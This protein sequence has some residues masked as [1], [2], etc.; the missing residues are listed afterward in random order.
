M[1]KPHRISWDDKAP[2]VKQ[3]NPRLAFQLSR[4]DEM[5]DELY[6]TTDTLT[7]PDTSLDGFINVRDYGTLGDGTQDEWQYLQKAID[8]AP[9]V[10]KTVFIPEGYYTISQPLTV[11][12][13]TRIVGASMGGSTHGIFTQEDSQGSVIK[14][15]GTGVTFHLVDFA[16]STNKTS[17]QVTLEN[18]TI[19]GNKTASSHGIL[20]DNP[21]LVH[22]V[23][24]FV[25]NHG[26]VGIDVNGGAY[27]S[28]WGQS[29]VIKGCWIT[30]NYTGG[31]RIGGSYRPTVTTVQDCS[32]LAGGKYLVY[33]SNGWITNLIGNEFASLSYAGL[34]AATQPHGIVIDQAT[35]VNIIGNSFESISGQVGTPVKYIRTGWNGDTQ[36]NTSGGAQG[37]R[38]V[39]NSFNPG[40]PDVDLVHARICRG[41]VFE[42]NFIQDGITGGTNR[43][44]VLEG[45]ENAWPIFDV[46]RNHYFDTTQIT[47][48]VIS[49][50]TYAANRVRTPTY[51][52]NVAININDTAGNA[53]QFLITAT[54][55]TAFTVQ[56]PV[57]FGYG[58]VIEITISN[59]SGGALGVVTWDT[60]YKL[61][62]WVS[63]ATANNR[64]I[65]FRFNTNG[66][67]YEVS[68]TTADVP[69]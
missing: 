6:K 19:L 44:L 20:I 45:M 24:C 39:G 1:S 36:A 4:A 57:G 7:A 35:E 22:I 34:V 14:N 28:S 56:N 55:G 66:N 51:G 12:S 18:L 17:M 33:V 62:A 10:G 8:A 9:A 38:I 48:L 43:G 41:L 52:A 67:W 23:N 32:V 49:S 60:L 27:S 58:D 47:P 65:R 26:G 68:R 46:E 69:N 2:E 37:V 31:I 5:L 64:S 15:E 53:K 40:T 54:N 11:R 21:A 16:T 3:V 29:T 25:A 63:P 13:H 59:T 61:A 50:G 30:H 42:G